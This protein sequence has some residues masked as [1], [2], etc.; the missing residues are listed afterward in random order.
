MTALRGLKHA[1]VVAMLRDNAKSEHPEVREAAEQSMQ[2]IFGPNW[3]RMRAVQKPVQPP[4]S[5]DKDRGP[6]GGW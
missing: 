5:D 4:V 2:A 3:N 6:P 1:A